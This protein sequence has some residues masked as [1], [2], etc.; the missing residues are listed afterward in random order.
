MSILEAQKSCDE[1]SRN[2]FFASILKGVIWKK[3]IVNGF[4]H[5]SIKA[6]TLKFKILEA[7]KNITEPN[8]FLLSISRKKM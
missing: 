2:L 4:S 5:N 6:S 3:Y 7:K 1:N 8:F